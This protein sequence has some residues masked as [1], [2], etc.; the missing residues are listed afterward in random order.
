[1]N[2]NELSKAHSKLRECTSELGSGFEQ[3]IKRDIQT[4]KEKE[5][6]KGFFFSTKAQQPQIRR[7]Y[8]RLGRRK[9]FY[10]VVK[11]WTFFQGI[12]L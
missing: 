3:R 2:K 4:S 1:M 12:L 8:L 11:F 10:L 7:R 9:Q 6:E 5:I